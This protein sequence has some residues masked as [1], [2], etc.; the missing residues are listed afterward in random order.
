MIM[1][2]AKHGNNIGHRCDRLTID[3]AH[4]VAKNITATFPGCTLMSSKAGRLEIDCNRG[5]DPSTELEDFTRVFN[6]L[7]ASVRV[8]RTMS[9]LRSALS[10]NKGPDRTGDHPDTMME[11]LRNARDVKQYLRLRFQEG[12]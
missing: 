8:R 5:K 2:L 3:A 10:S 6:G 11:A 4:D 9:T 12:V 1:P 7:V